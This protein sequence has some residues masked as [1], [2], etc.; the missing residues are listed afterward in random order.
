M[1]AQKCIIVTWNLVTEFVEVK[2]VE[3]GIFTWLHYIEKKHLST[4][5]CFR[6]VT[7]Q[8]ILPG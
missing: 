3:K 1:G 4:E 7:D 8:S 5:V 6:G 2:M